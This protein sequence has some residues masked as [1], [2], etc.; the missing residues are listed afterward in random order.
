MHLQLMN[1][2]NNNFEESVEYY[3]G[4]KMTRLQYGE[5]QST[6]ASIAVSPSS[7]GFE[8]QHRCFS[9]LL[10]LSTVL[11]SNPSSSEPIQLAATSQAKKEEKFTI[12]T[13]GF[14][15]FSR[16]RPA[17]CRQ[18]IATNFS[19]WVLKLMKNCTS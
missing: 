7:P 4:A 10:S 14:F 18:R 13:T 11:R 12:W 5:R 15:S 19:N 2:M 16:R 8:S 1:L 9:K 3:L 17:S 6:E